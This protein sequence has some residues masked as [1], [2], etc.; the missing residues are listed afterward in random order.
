VDCLALNK[1]IEEIRFRF[2]NLNEFIVNKI[3]EG[4]AKNQK[5]K[6]LDISENLCEDTG[7]SNI[8]KMLEEN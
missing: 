1:N 2:C 4:L 3:V 5:L 6:H 8:L 7:G